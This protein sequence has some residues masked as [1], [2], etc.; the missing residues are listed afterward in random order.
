MI[1]YCIII[2]KNYGLLSLQEKNFKKRFDKKDYRL[3]VI[4]NTPD[5][6]KQNYQVDS[7]V[8]D[9]FIPMPSQ[10]RF[11]GISHGSAIDFGL[12]YCKSNIVAIIDSDFFVLNNEIHDYVNKKFDQGYRALGC[13]FNDGTD[14]TLYWRQLNPQNFNNIP[15]CYGAYYDRQVANA[16]SWIITPDEVDQGRA[17]GFIEVGFRIRQHI[18]QH[19]LPTIAWTTTMSKPCFF[20]DQDQVLMGVHYVAG[21]HQRSGQENLTIISNLIDSY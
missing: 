18:L 17:T 12:S 2:Y 16:A 13:E 15:C 8:V 11:D 21:S 9:E 19:Q 14:A 4:D 20:K 1:D 10:E 6:L 3:I 7:S 5:H